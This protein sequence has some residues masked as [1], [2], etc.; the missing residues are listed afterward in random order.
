MK[1][2]INKNSQL[3]N[4]EKIS[5]KLK[6]D[7]DF[8]KLLEASTKTGIPLTFRGNRIVDFKIHDNKNFENIIPDQIEIG[9]PAIFFDILIGDK[10]LKEIPF[11]RIN[12]N[13]N[14]MVFNSTFY[15]PIDFKIKIKV[16]VNDEKRELLFNISINPK[17]NNIQDIL[18]YE[19]L[20][21]DFSN[22]ILIIK[23]S[24]IDEK[25]FEGKLPEEEYDESLIQFYKKIVTINKK[26]NLNLSI[27]EEYIIRQNDLECAD[28]ICK[29]LEN[30]KIPITKL[31]INMEIDSEMLY[32]FIYNN[33]RK[34]VLEQNSYIV[35]L[36]GNEIN[37]GSCKIKMNNYT[38]LNEEE[39]IN[40]LESNKENNENLHI[41]VILKENNSEDFYL[42]F[43]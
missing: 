20:K 8:N 22:K 26:M 24:E 19:L 36:L 29:Y 38:I 7:K 27:D 41:I 32:K 31:S 18:N 12:I 21:K 11:E 3:N 9:P 1:N 15:S 13:E 42:D 25:V 2:E 33:E 17:S 43:N 14:V 34:L 39:L 30:K 5:L 16:T 28:S 35:E 23:L 10:I 4:P 40:I 37:L 6:L